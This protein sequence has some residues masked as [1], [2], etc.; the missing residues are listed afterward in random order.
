MSNDEIERLL[1]AFEDCSL[2]KEEWTHAAHLTVAACYTLDDPER[3]LQRA[4]EG[5]QRFNIAKGVPQT[6]TGGYHETITVFFM[7]MVG[8]V[9]GSLDG[10]PP[11][12]K[13]GRVVEAL[14]D[15]RA[16]LEYYSR[17][18]IMSREAR[19]GWVEPDLKALP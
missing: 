10:L 5:I 13:V 9:L 17:D 12:E 18:L 14:R 6:D 16:P 8:H 7:H 15:P 19:Y 4:R 3:A 1:A 11:C 2:P